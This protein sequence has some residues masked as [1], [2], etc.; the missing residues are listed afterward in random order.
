MDREVGFGRWRLDMCLDVGGDGS[1]AMGV[2]K[3]HLDGAVGFGQVDVSHVVCTARRN[4][5]AST[6]GYCVSISEY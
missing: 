2:V 4:K 1:G 3:E 6:V 5:L